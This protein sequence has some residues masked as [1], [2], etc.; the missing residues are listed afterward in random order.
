MILNHHNHNDDETDDE[1]IE[2]EASAKITP[3]GISAGI[4]VL[5]LITAFFWTVSD[6]R[7]QMA[8][9]SARLTTMSQRLLEDE[10]KIDDLDAHGTRGLLETNSIVK[11]LGK[12]V[13]DLTDATRSLSEAIIRH[14][15][16]NIGDYRS[17]K[18]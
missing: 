4:A 17:R 15:N 7:V 3:Q 13:D 1:N 14:N 11:Q 2:T 16:D 6:F 9:I 18:R 5:G 10:K 8:D 12:Q